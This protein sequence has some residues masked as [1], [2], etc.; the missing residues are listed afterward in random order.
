MTC[1]SGTHKW[2]LQMIVLIFSLQLILPN[3]LPGNT[4]EQ[5]TIANKVQSK[6][7]GNVNAD[8]LLI[9]LT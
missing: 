2:A 3:V 9:Q 5:V 7:N 8:H 1:D 4:I 6:N